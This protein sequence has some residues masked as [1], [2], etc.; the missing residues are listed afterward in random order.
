[1]ATFTVTPGKTFADETITHTKLNSLASPSIALDANSVELG[2]I[3][4][5]LMEPVVVDLTNETTYTLDTERTYHVARITLKANKTL[6]FANLTVGMF[7]TLTVKQSGGTYSLT[8]SPT[9]LVINAGGGVL[10]L[11]ASDGAIDRVSWQY[12]S[13]SSFLMSQA[14][15]F[16]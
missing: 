14:T 16:T 9:P 6:T 1:M 5:G 8:I 4:K 15:N 12:F 2:D 3:R 13:S 11:T 10:S 7:G